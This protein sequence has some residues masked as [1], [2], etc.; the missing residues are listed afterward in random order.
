ME[1]WPRGISKGRYRGRAG[2][3]RSSRRLGLQQRVVEADE[4]GWRWRWC[5]AHFAQDERGIDNQCAARTGERAGDEDQTYGRC[6]ED[7]GVQQ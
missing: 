3:R 2:P 1:T 5:V 6:R 7:D 4:A